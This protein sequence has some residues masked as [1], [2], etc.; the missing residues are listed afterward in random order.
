MFVSQLS[1][2][3]VRLFVCWRFMCR[4]CIKHDGYVMQRAV[5]CLD[6]GWCAL[7]AAV[8]TIWA[9]THLYCD[10]HSSESTRGSAFFTLAF[11][12]RVFVWCWIVFYYFNGDLR[13]FWSSDDEG[14]LN[15]RVMRATYH[16]D[17][18]VR[19]V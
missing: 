2:R 16:A 5:H 9:K 8:K 6:G 7:S 10:D 1:G 18:Y 3:L 15:E 4:E 17:T 19:Q 11:T 12:E 13:Y 14:V